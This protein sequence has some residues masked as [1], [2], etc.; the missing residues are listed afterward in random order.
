MS[1][2]N[3]ISLK[4][5]WRFLLEV[6]LYQMISGH[7]NCMSRCALDRVHVVY[8]CT[9]IRISCDNI[10]LCKEQDSR[11][12]EA[13]DIDD[14]VNL[15][16][17]RV[18][19]YIQ[20]TLNCLKQ[21]VLYIRY[22]VH[23]ICVPLH[24]LFLSILYSPQVS[25]ET[26]PRSDVSCHISGKMVI[27]CGEDSLTPLVILATHTLCAPVIHVYGFFMFSRDDFLLTL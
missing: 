17:T 2:L 12:D 8:V 10:V 22:C 20:C 1:L 5:K 21:R 19:V 15:S 7:Q 3:N 27:G 9:C 18:H 4:S 11:M 13:M 16:V 26:Y 25:S 23:N 14:K 6:F 24:T